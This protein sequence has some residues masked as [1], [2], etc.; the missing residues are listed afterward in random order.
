VT[1]VEAERDLVTLPAP[2]RR[3]RT[4]T[5]VAMAACALAAGLLAWSL[6]PEARFVLREPDLVDVGRLA[7]AELRAGEEGSFARAGVAVQDAQTVSFRRTLDPGSW[8]VARDGEGRWVAY[9]VPDEVAGPRFVPPA[10]VAGRL[11]RVS[12][13]GV[14]FRGLEAALERVSG[15]D[16]A[17]SWL[18]VDGEDPN[19]MSWVLGLEALL[20]AFVIFNLA[21]MARLLRRVR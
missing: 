2:D 19:D 18:L 8:R 12:E 13:A 20:A 6:L 10:L 16:E 1:P 4:I 11:V 7:D 14:R 3:V 5:L 9:L 21:G 17:E 15:K